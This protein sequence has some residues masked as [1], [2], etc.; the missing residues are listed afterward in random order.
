MLDAPSPIHYALVAY[1]RG[2]VAEFVESLRAELHPARPH[3]KAHVTILPPRISLASEP[4]AVAHLRMLAPR[5]TAFDIAFDNVETF[6]PASPTVFIRV[7]KSAHR[8]R[9]M[10]VAFNTGALQCEEPWTYIPHLT[11]VKMDGIPEAA[12]A[13]EMARKRWAAFKGQRTATIETLTFV[14]E[15]ETDPW[16]DLETIQ[17]KGK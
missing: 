14:R 13:L 11:I 15:G 10:H 12:H 4:D 7:T 2:S 6:A 5:F 1:L 9:D 8:F 3:L 17:L 16:V